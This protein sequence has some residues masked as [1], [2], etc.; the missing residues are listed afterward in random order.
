MG[1]QK[2][3]PE[4]LKQRTELCSF[5]NSV[6]CSVAPLTAAPEQGIFLSVLHGALVTEKTVNKMMAGK[7]KK[8]TDGPTSEVIQIMCLK[9]IKI[10]KP[11]L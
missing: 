10:N 9:K 5:K 4:P 1:G 6:P 11:H 8:Y 7:S 2:S 3:V